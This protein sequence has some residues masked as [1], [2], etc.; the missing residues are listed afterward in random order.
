M[1]QNEIAKMKNN[2]RLIGDQ[3]YMFGETFGNNMSKEE[4]E[5]KSGILNHGQ[6]Y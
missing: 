3:S 4:E 1:G 5:N 2:I 6:G